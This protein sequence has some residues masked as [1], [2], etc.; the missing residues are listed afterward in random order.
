MDQ[1]SPTLSVVTVNYKR[2]PQ[3]QV[4]KKSLDAVENVTFEW[5][6]VDNFGTTDEAK[7]VQELVDNTPYMHAIFLNENYGFSRGCN[8]GTQFA[9]GE[10]ICFLNPDTSVMPNTFTALIEGLKRNTDAVIV[11]PQMQDFHGNA[12]ENTYPLPTM[13]RKIHRRLMLSYPSIQPITGDAAVGFAQG[14]FMLMRRDF[15]EKIGGFD[16]R[17][18]L[19]MDDSDL[20]R[21]AWESGGRVMQ[22]HDAVA[23]HDSKRLSGRDN[24][25]LS[26]RRWT[27]WTHVK[28]TLLYFWKYRGKRN[29]RVR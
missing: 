20:C 7:K 10:Y 19:F 2:M 29:P 8:E 5:V 18:F 13:W 25:L 3:L 27:F 15:F 17:F 22:I 1:K 4:L 14:S 26:L 24:I 12:T 21:R 23:I 11:T 6:L 9:S 28:S 16:E